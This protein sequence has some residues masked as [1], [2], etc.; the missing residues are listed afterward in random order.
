MKICIDGMYLLNGFL[1]PML[2]HS[3]VKFPCSSKIPRYL[4]CFVQE[5]D[6]IEVEEIA[7]TQGNW[8][9][10]R[11]NGKRGMFPAV[12]VE[13]TGSSIHTVV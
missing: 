13:E 9:W 3:F 4:S 5:G 11:L 2:G 10:G 8:R 6:V 12:F 7:D 1:I